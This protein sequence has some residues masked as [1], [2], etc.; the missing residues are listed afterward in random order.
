[1]VFKIKLNYEFSLYVKIGNNNC[2]ILLFRLNVI[3]QTS[4]QQIPK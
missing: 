2:N 1:M 4:Y 3:M